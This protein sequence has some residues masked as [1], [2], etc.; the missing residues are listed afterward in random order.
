M[1]FLF[2]RKPSPRRMPYKLVLVGGGGVGKTTF[3]DFLLKHKKDDYS[4]EKRYEPTIGGTVADFTL[5]TDHGEVKFYVWD[6]AGQERFGTLRDAYVQGADAIFVMYNVSDRASIRGMDTWLQYARRICPGVPI[7][8]CGNQSDKLRDPTTDNRSL[9]RFRSA[10]LGRLGEDPRLETFLMSV[11]RM[12]GVWEPL[13]WFA[14][15][16]LY[17]DEYLRKEVKLRE[18]APPSYASTF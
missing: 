18:E 13:T 14:S 4:F 11:K 17:K 3:G 8:I 2:R 12:E 1:S 7:A 6:T 15:H 16:L 9:V 5:P 10:R